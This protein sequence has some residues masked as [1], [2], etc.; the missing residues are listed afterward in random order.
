MGRLQAR[1]ART[2]SLD[3]SRDAQGTVGFSRTEK[4]RVQAVQVLGTRDNHHRGKGERHAA[5]ART[6]TGGHPRD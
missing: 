3:P 2:A 6:S 1:G 4:D 5:H